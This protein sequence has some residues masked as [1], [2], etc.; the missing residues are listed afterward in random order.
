MPLGME[1]LEGLWLSGSLGDVVDESRAGE[2]DT[3]RG[4]AASDSVPPEGRVTVA[5][6]LE[7]LARALLATTFSSTFPS[8]LPLAAP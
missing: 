2:D 4:D 5:W 6:G 7:V 1:P 8:L 3:V